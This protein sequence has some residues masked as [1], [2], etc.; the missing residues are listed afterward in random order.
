[1]NIA[2]YRNRFFSMCIMG[3]MK[4][5]MN[6]EELTRHFVI[7]QCVDGKMTVKQAAERL[8]LK[9]RRIKQLKKEFKEVGVV[10]VIHGNAN[11][12][13][14]KRLPQELVEKI[15]AI[16]KLEPLNK[17]NFIHFHEILAERYGI[18][19][20]YSSL[21]RT[22]TGVGIKSPKNRRKKK[23]L[24]PSRPRKPALGMML[25]A[26]A[27]PH[28]WFG[29]SENYSLHGFIDDATSR[30]TGLYICKN[31]CLLGY[32]EVLRQTLTNYGIPQSL[33]P[34]QYSVFFVNPKHEQQ[35][36]VEDQLTGVEKRLTQFGKI[37]E[38][39]GVEMFPAH[40]PQAK[41]RVERL[42]ET[43]QSRL[44]IEFA[45]NGIS[46]V[47][48]A[49]D[50]LLHYID[51]FNKQFAVEPVESYSAF[52]PVPHTEDLDRLLSVKIERSLSSGSTISI[53]N[54]LFKIEQNR[55]PSRTKVTVLIS[56]KFGMRALIN[57][58]FYPIYPIN[59]ITQKVD[60]VV[61]T[62]DLPTVIVDLIQYYL[63]SDAKK[64]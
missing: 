40:S 39:L 29:G 48:A 9:E 35:L 31:E 38:R 43:L 42:W 30:V 44:P 33:Y 24:H 50:F 52:V 18:T 13:S 22:L 17:S 2:P 16:R 62:G 15:I 14:P 10:A 53:R 20:S 11:K 47:K 63:M 7:K 1:M 61:R 6:K 3:D 45:L 59:K 4:Y 21:Y 64:P 25:Q 23:N 49:N 8:G 37:V 51:R 36:S 46:D 54:K 19:I 26:D 56:E 12:P 5:I 34:D 57:G 41:G 55:F 28:L 60:D 58:A 32:L 27:A